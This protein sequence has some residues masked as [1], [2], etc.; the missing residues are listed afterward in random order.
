[1]KKYVVLF[2]LM[3][4]ALSIH[5]QP[6][7][8]IFAGPQVTGAKY[9]INGCKQPVTSKYGFQLGTVLKVPFENNLY[10]APEIFYSLKGYKVEFNQRAFPP[11][12]LAVDNNTSIHTCELAFLLQYDLGKQ[13]NHFFIKAGPSIDV[14]LAGTEK[15]NLKNGTNMD[16]PMKFSFGDYGRFGANLLFQLGY[17]TGSGFI[18][19]GMYT[20]GVGSINNADYGP[21]IRH[22]AFGFAIGKYFTGKKK[23]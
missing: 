4:I 18:I 16:Q 7:F 9:S 21:S 11:D 2:I 10:F 15:Y 6:V 19:K 17:E 1:M 23:Q 14:Q 5:A 20:H 3:G 12:T 22:R 13:K 8:G